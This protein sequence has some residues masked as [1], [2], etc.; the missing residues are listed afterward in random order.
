MDP[1]G[2]IAIWVKRIVG[3][4]RSGRFGSSDAAFLVDTDSLKIASD[5]QIGRIS[6]YLPN[7]DKIFFYYSRFAP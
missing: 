2:S 1:A 5:I 4:L 7:R 6:R 3:I